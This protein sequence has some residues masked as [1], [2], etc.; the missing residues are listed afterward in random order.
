MLG[1]GDGN[2]KEDIKWGNGDEDGF[3][4]LKGREHSFCRCHFSVWCSYAK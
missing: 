4:E 2:R 3:K 1:T